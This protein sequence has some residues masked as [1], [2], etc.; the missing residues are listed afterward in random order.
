MA[1]ANSNFFST[2]Q[3][4]IGLAY[5]RSLEENLNP[6]F[7]VNNLVN[8]R[9]TLL[10]NLGPTEVSNGVNIVNAQLSTETTYNA[11]TYNVLK[12]ILSALNSFYTT[13]YG[14]TIRDFFNGINSGS[15]SLVSWNNNF[16]DSYKNTFANEVVQQIGFVTYYN[17]A[18]YFVPA[19]SSSSLNN[20]N[21]NY[22]VSLSTSGTSATLLGI[23]SNVGSYVL[24]GFN[25]ITYNTF[26]SPNLVGLQTQSV[27]GFA[28]TNTITLSTTATGSNAYFYRPIQNAEL[29]EF[30]Y[31][32][33]SATGLAATA[34]LGTVNVTVG[35]ANTS[36][37]VQLTSG[38]SRANIFPTGGST[39]VFGSTS[40]KS[41]SID[42]P[43]NLG[44]AQCLE[45]W[46]KGTN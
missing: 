24:P 45:V 21:I 2:Y 44:T 8:S 43:A 39:T 38:T 4:Y 37:V 35:L 46:V 10:N 23:S 14:Y 6:N 34:I 42:T 40:I 31:A 9:Q 7:V 13:T 19:L 28:N 36:F 1:L 33:S 41:V 29:F 16:K 22:Q 11:N 25:V 32:S 17:G 12:T 27:I 20:T 26:P 5:G 15:L 30:R 18:S 3:A